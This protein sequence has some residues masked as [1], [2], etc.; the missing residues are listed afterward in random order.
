MCKGKWSFGKGQGWNEKGGKGGG[1]NREAVVRKEAKGKRELARDKPEHVG[2]VARQD[3]LQLGA[4]K[5]T[6]NICTPSMKMPVKNIEESADNEEDLQAWC[7]LEESENEQWQDVITRN[8]RRLKKAN[9]ASLLSVVISHKSS[10]KKI[11]H[12]KDRRV[13]VSVTMDSGAAGHVMLETMFPRVKLE[14]TTSP[15]KF[16]SKWRTDKR[17]G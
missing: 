4:R 6:A 2:R 1:D 10:S 13:K 15:K 8:K 16:G 9:Q 7:L 17:L 14:R 3:T 12:V 5:E 11:V